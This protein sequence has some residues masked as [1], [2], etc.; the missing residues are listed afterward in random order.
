MYPI[1]DIHVEYSSIIQPKCGRVNSGETVDA[2][3]VLN[4]TNLTKSKM[5][6]NLRD[7]I[8]LKS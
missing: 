5:L 6:T 3:A 1:L 8:Y 7:F 4:Y 2:R